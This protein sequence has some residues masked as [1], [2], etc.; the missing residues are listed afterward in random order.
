MR[1]KTLTLTLAPILGA[2]AIVSVPIAPTTAT[3]LPTATSA[4][5]GA[6]SLPEAPEQVSTPTPVGTVESDEAAI[7]ASAR[8]AARGATPIRTVPFFSQFADIDDP[9]WRKVACGVASLAM[10]VEYH[11]EGTTDANRELA[12]GISANAYTDNGW[13]HR[14]LIELAERHNLR[15]ES[16]SLAHLSREAAVAA[17]TKAVTDNPVMVSVHYTFEPTNPIPHLVVVTDI[18]DGYVHYND[19]AEPAGGGFITTERF[20][21][22]WKQRYIAFTPL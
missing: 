16:V 10:I 1:H 22:A 7:T 19:P 17:L 2:L 14:G 21:A 12:A 13:S 15:G 5:A 9:A 6:I 20:A 3:N 11:Y 8:E 18:R 4:G